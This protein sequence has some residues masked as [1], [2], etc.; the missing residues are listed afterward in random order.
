MYIETGMMF[1]VQTVAVWYA[2]LEGEGILTAWQYVCYTML[3][4]DVYVDRLN[5][6]VTQ[7]WEKMCM[8]TDWQYICYTVLEE[9]VYVDRLAIHLLH[10]VGRRDVC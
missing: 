7:C 6:F 1:C 10:S 4:E 2:K 9:D 8:L 3:E 5:T